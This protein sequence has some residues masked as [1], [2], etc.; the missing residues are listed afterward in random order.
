M[1]PSDLPDHGLL[2]GVAPAQRRELVATSG[3]R[4]LADGD[5]LVRPGDPDQHVWLVLDG[6]VAIRVSDA[7]PR[8]VMVLGP[9]EPVG[10]LTALDGGDRSAWAV[11][12]GPT[13]VLEIP[14]KAFLQ[15]LG[16][17]HA[18]A[19]NLLHL[20]ARR[21][22]VGNHAIT[23]SQRARERT[24]RAGQRDGLTGVYNRAWL[25]RALPAVI[26]SC[27]ERDVDLC[28]V[29][30]DVDHFKKLNDTYG[31]PTGDAVLVELGRQLRQRFRSDDQVA[32]YGGEEFAVLL[33]GVDVATAGDVVDRVRTAL[34]LTGVPGPDGQVVRFTIS[35]GVAQLGEGESVNQLLQR[36]DQALYRAKQGGRDQVVTA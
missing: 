16:R 5:V 27:R 2:A 33:P 1:K 36:T 18:A 13:A 35:A 12:E 9:G 24:E 25:D 4:T 15:L 8:P 22:R 32:R 21:V 20:V 26:H 17:S 7:D 34:A 19:L 6:A 11:A 30:I 31:H 29:L 28:L 14:R 23:R 3:V 10:E